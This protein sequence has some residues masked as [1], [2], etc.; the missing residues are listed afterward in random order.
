[1]RFVAAIQECRLGICTGMQS[2][3]LLAYLN[4]CY[5]IINPTLYKSAG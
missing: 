3:T 4:D 1:M 2:I 5:S